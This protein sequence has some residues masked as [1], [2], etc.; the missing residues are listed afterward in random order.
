MFSLIPLAHAQ[1]T[2]VV[3]IGTTFGIG[4]VVT[5]VI[6]FLAM[7]IGA[8]S[9]AIFIAGAFM[10]VVSRGQDAQVQKGKDLMKG[11]LFG[12]VTVL[13]AYAILR[14]VFYLVFP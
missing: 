13:G 7:S 14:V 10:V 3:N 6:N 11:A 9:S 12:L 8:I 2:L 5:G 1:R 4:A